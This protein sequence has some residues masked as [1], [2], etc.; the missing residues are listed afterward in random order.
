[1]TGDY[2][3]NLHNITIDSMKKYGFL[4]IALLFSAIVSGVLYVAVSLSEA[5]NWNRTCI[6]R[7]GSADEQLV[8]VIGDSWVAGGKLDSGLHHGFSNAGIKARV[9]TTG[10]PGARS[11]LIYENF[12]SFSK[13]IDAE[14]SNPPVTYVIEGGIN[15]A[16]AYVGKDF[17][18]KHVRLAVEAALQCSE[19][20]VVLNIPRFDRRLDQRPVFTQVRWKI[21]R[22]LSGDNPDDNAKDYNDALAAELAPLVQSGKVKIIDMRSILA[23]DGFSGAMFDGVHL[24]PAKYDDLA[25]RLG[26]EISDFIRSPM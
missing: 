1:M 15:D 7:P 2:I 4:A 18:A 21:Y 19:R 23:G 20:A 12:E 5:T 22:T 9:K 3:S 16:L 6:D 17:Y 10:H 13:W 24:P 11:K 8:A 25:Y 26:K 14:Y